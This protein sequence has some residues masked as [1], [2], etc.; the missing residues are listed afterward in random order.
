MAK[1]EE[2]NGKAVLKASLQSA[3]CRGLVDLFQSKRDCFHVVL[4]HL[5]P[6]LDVSELLRQKQSGYNMHLYS[7][8]LAYLESVIKGLHRANPLRSLLR[9]ASSLLLQLLSLRFKLS[10]P[11]GV[12]RDLQEP[13][14]GHYL[15]VKDETHVRIDRLHHHFGSLSDRVDGGLPQSF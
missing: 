3:S 1:R 14:P 5:G 11:S 4:D 2:I 9:E 13:S 6:V 7:S 12:R 8:A 15:I 10:L